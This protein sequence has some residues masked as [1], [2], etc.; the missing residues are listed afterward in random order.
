MVEQAP[1]AITT[2]P[3]K[4]AF[5]GQRCKPFLVEMFNTTTVDYLLVYDKEH[6]ETVLWSMLEFFY[7]K[8]IPE[9]GAKRGMTRKVITCDVFQHQKGGWVVRQEPVKPGIAYHS[10]PMYLC[11]D[12]SYTRGSMGEWFLQVRQYHNA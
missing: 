10:C 2:Y 8:D 3:T 12:A 11:E 4:Q 9:A 1:R 7:H 5:I 6:K